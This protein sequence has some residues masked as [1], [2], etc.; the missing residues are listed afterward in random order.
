M[1]TWLHNLHNQVRI[2]AR[3]TKLCAFRCNYHRR[4]AIHGDRLTTAE[5]SSTPRQTVTSIRTQS[6][7]LIGYP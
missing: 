1:A 5:C 3:P 6:F 7:S 2:N 4:V